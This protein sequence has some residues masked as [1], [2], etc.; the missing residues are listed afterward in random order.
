MRNRSFSITAEVDIPKGGAEGVL[1]AQGGMI[2]GH[3]FFVNK[4]QKL[5]FSHNYVG[6]EEYK[7]V[8]ARQD[9]RRGRR[10]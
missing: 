1:L 5:Q 6:L 2:G 7:V 4:D 3:T 9:S 10:P 8:S